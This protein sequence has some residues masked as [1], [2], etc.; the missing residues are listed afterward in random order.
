MLSLVSVS[1]RLLGEVFARGPFSFMCHFF[2]CCILRLSRLRLTHFSSSFTLHFFWFH[3]CVGLNGGVNICIL[4]GT[5]ELNHVRKTRDCN[6]VIQTHG[7][8]A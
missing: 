5:R 2:L 1:T 7:I 8:G 6:H 3:K 4:L